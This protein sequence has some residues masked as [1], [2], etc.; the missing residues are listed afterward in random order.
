MKYLVIIIL[1]LTTFTACKKHNHCTYVA[2]KGIV[3]DPAINAYSFRYVLTDGK[4][5]STYINYEIGD[6]ICF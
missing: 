2:Q 3:F 6:K 1:A 4:K 5:Y